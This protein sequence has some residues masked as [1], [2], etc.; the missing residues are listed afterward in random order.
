MDHFIEA[1][2]WLLHDSQ[3]LSAGHL[4]KKGGLS[5]PTRDPP[6]YAENPP[7]TR[8]FWYADV[9]H[10]FWGVTPGAILFTCMQLLQFMS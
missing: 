6:M 10:I 5:P 4:G 2:E 7:L 9:L 3:W 8:D 1:C